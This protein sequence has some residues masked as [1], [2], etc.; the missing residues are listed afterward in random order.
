MKKYTPIKMIRAGRYKVCFDGLEPEVQAGV[1]YRKETLITD[2]REWCDKGNYGHLC[3]ILPTIA[4]D[5]ALQAHGKTADEAY[6]IISTHMWAALTPEM[7]IKLSRLPFFFSVMRK[8]IPLGFKYGSGKGW[9]YVWHPDDP[10]DRY[11]FETLE[12]L[13]RHIFE[14][15]GLLERF[16][17]M[18]CHSDIINYGNLYNLDFIRTQ[19][20]CQGGDKCDFCFVRHRKCEVWERTKSI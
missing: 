16:G 8:I 12:C 17:P 9:R 4:I 18:F 14:K 10:K 6:E 5:E 2:N 19:T 20:L 15:Y 13:Y 11:H 7:Y 3:N 1:L